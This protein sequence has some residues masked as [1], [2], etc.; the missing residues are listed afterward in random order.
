MED[1]KEHEETW[2]DSLLSKDNGCPLRRC[3]QDSAVLFV[4]GIGEDA[5]VYSP[6]SDHAG[7]LGEALRIKCEREGLEFAE[8]KM[9]K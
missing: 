3:S 8:Y 6:C 5:R 1:R 4:A 7:P 2:L 9:L